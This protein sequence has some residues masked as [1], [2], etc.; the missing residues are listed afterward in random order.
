MRA[1]IVK[2]GLFT[3]DNHSCG[4][5]LNRF[6]IPHYANHTLFHPCPEKIG[7]QK[8]LAIE[9]YTIDKLLMVG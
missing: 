2:S 3:P 4:R 9:S 5:R 8:E 6:Q 7:W 1:E